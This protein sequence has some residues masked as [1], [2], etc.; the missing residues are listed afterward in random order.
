MGVRFAVIGPPYS[1][2][3]TM[4]SAISGV[5]GEHLHE[6]QP[7]SG[8]HL[9]T[10][11]YEHDPRLQALH[12]MHNSKKTTPAMFEIMDFPG[13]DLTD[14]TGREH[15]QRVVAEVR[16]CDLLI[17]VLRA[18][19]DSSVPAYRDRID[20]QADL[21]ELT[22]E[23][24]FA[25]MEQITRRIQKL[26]VSSKKPTPT[27]N[28]EL[29][30]KEMEM[31]KRCLAA[32]EQGKPVDQVPNGAE[33]MKMLK[34]F[35]LLTQ[36]PL[37]VIINVSEDQL[38]RKF[39]LKLGGMIKGSM[40]CA[41]KFEQ[42]LWQLSE[43]DRTTFMAEAGVTEPVQNRLI[44]MGLDGLNMILF[45]TSGEDDARAWLLEKGAKAV[46][47]AGKIH[48][49]ISRGFIRAETVHYDDLMAIGSEKQARAAGKLRLEGK[50]YIVKDGDVIEFRFNV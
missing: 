37:L 28:K 31:L 5:G 27:A 47:A 17:I 8:M 23:F 32:L 25:D 12:K 1:G 24:V 10:L 33:E 3:T 44:K 43:E 29:E 30:K 6:V 18:F 13:F 49:D 36:H 7:G 22:D 2:K 14:Q 26:E 38:T 39:D 42:E 35:T 34:G 11:K 9:A 20:P 48:S 16:Q 21:D 19:E 46:E 45:Y 50:D 15:V 4:L 41:G 40:V